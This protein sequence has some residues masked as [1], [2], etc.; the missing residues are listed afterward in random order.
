M[1]NVPVRSCTCVCF[2]FLLLFGFFQTKGR[3]K[4]QRGGLDEKNIKGKG[5]PL[6]FLVSFFFLYFLI[7]SLDLFKDMGCYGWLALP[8]S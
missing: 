8:A 1:H 6:L 7:P 2:F 3:K 5:D 4:R